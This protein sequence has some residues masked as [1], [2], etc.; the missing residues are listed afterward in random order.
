MYSGGLEE[1]TT[2]NTPVTPRSRKFTRARCH[3]E[4][5]IDV[6]STNKIYYRRTFKFTMAWEQRGTTKVYYRSKRLNGRVIKKY[7]GTGRTAQLAYEEDLRKQEAIEQERAMRKEIQA[8]DQQTNSVRDMTRTITN[9]HFLLGGY[10]QHHRGEWRKQRQQ[11]ITCTGDTFM[12]PQTQEQ[13]KLLIED[14][15]SLV[16]QA[17]RGDESTL[18]AIKQFLD[19]AP[20]LWQDVFSV[21]KKVEKAWITTIAQQNLFTQEALIREVSELKKLLQAEYSSTLESLVIES[22][23]TCFLAYKQAELTASQQL[24]HYGTA[25]TQAQQNHLTA[26][27]KRYLLAVKELA[28]IRQLLTPRNTTVLNIA[29]QQQVNVT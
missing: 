6:R 13:K 3:K 29:N 19:N 15:E 8:L 12:L 10:H 28:R 5:Q 21:T 2:L 25:L 20:Y 14:I 24:Q 9:A 11:I 27:Q 22:I 26:C 4:G 23:C 18:P 1:Q 16:Q 17:M 7:Y